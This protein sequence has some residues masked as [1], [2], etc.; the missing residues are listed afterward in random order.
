MKELTSL[1]REV[2]RMLLAGDDE[3]LS[4]LRAQLETATVAK[5][6]MTGVGFYTTF[7]ISPVAPRAGNL[8]FR[9]GDVEASIRGLKHGAGFLLFVKL[10]ALEMLEGYTYDEPWP[11]D[12]SEFT[13]SYT[14]GH[15]RDM[16]AFRKILHGDNP[17][18]S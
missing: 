18:S 16:M 10:G 13:L 11:P 15:E 17:T 5:R 6:E 3:L 8:A 4:I 7:E 2:L 14:T 1:E 9:F 12:T